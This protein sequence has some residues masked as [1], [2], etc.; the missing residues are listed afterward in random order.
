MQSKVA[1][2]LTKPS[3]VHCKTTNQAVPNCKELHVLNL[4]LLPLLP[5]LCTL[6]GTQTILTAPSPRI[7]VDQL[8]PQLTV[9][10]F[11]E[12]QALPKLL[13]ILLLIRV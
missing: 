12:D 3:S 2:F 11:T 5:F 1:Q 9:F 6:P 4:V 13:M 8:G 7:T 10:V